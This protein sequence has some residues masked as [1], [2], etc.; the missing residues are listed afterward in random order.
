[1]RPY[2]LR[3]T[4]TSKDIVS[5]GERGGGEGAGTSAE[6]VKKRKTRKYKGKTDIKRKKMQE[7]QR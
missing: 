1:M 5:W 6:N 2:L 3:Q 4:F 7:E